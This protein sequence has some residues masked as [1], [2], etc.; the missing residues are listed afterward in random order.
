MEANKEIELTGLQDTIDSAHEDGKIP[1]FFDTTGNA[2]RFLT[3]TASVIDIAKHQVGIQLGATTVDDVK[4]DI[5]LRFKGAMAYGKTLVFFLDKLAGNFKSDYFDPD[6]CPE[7]IF[8]PVAIRDAEV[9]M[10][11]VREEENVDNFGGKGNFMM[12]DEFKVIVVSTRDLDDEDNG[13][14]EERMPMDHM[15]IIRIV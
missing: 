9:Y 3:Y 15:R 6:Y 2:E 1:F 4:E 10:K 13:Q 14:F 8:D 7:E 12:K 11:C 5:R